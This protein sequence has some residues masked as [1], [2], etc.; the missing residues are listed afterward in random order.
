MVKGLAEELL[1]IVKLKELGHLG[2]CLGTQGFV[3]SGVQEH[4]SD[5]EVIAEDSADQGSLPSVVDPIQ[6]SAFVDKNL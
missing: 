3:R 6:I 5:G 2:W 1:H 4:A